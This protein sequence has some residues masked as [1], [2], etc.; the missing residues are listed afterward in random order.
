MASSSDI[1]DGIADAATSPKSV[2]IDGTTTT[3]RSIDELIKADQYLRA[4][5]ARRGGGL[6]V[7]FHKIV[8]HGS[9]R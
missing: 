3:E 8:P 9:V 1:N 4:N 5:K 7:R 6:G 2:T